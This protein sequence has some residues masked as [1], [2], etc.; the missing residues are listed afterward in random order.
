MHTNIS[1]FF[2]KGG[3]SGLI[4]Q[5]TRTC[6]RFVDQ[7][8]SEELFGD[9]ILYQHWRAI[10]VKIFEEDLH[11][12]VMPERVVHQAHW[13]DSN[14]GG[15]HLNFISSILGHNHGKSLVDFRIK[16]VV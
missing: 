9:R 6:I 2:A 1:H 10:L 15:L 8:F 11:I 14:T 12:E 4:G 3:T 13:K 7:W 16:L 5:T